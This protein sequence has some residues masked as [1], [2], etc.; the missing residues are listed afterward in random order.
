[1]SSAE[2]VL[3][4]AAGRVAALAEIAVILVGAFALSASTL[5]VIRTNDILV[6]AA[7]LVLVSANLWVTLAGTSGPSLLALA[8]TASQVSSVRTFRGIRLIVHGALLAVAEDAHVDAQ[9]LGGERRGD[10]DVVVHALGRR[11]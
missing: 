6:F 2:L 11:E 4:L 8:R 10:V 7:H 3:D 9:E 1:M 5:A